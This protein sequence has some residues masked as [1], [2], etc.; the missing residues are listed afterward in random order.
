MFKYSNIYP[1]LSPFPLNFITFLISNSIFYMPYPF[2]RCAVFTLHVFLSFIALS[3]FFFTLPIFCSLYLHML[4]GTVTHRFMLCHLTFICPGSVLFF[5]NVFYKF[6]R[7]VSDFIHHLRFCFGTQMFRYSDV[8]AMVFSSFFST[9][10]KT[11]LCCL[12]FS[13]HPKN[14]FSIL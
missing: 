2:R 12:I 9:E 5:H 6:Q 8:P 14:F 7:S 4:V 3:N 10:K 13:F 11:H 1:S